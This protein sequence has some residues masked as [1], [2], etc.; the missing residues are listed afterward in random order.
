M[1]NAL[2][3]VA[4]NVEVMFYGVAFATV[5]TLGVLFAPAEVALGT[6]AAVIASLATLS[7]G[8]T[9]NMEKE[10]EKTN[11]EVGK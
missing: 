3:W 10:N 7:N 5:V 11:R 6:A 2:E 8:D 1:R 9:Q 4:E